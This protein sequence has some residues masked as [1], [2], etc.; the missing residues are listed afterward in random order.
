MC[1]KLFIEHK[2]RLVWSLMSICTR[3]YRSRGLCKT[4]CSQKLVHN[5]NI[6][7]GNSVEISDLGC[8]D[9]TYLDSYLLLACPFRRESQAIVITRTSSLLSCKPFNV[10][11]RCKSVKG[12]NTKLGILAHHDK[13]QLQDKEH[14]FESSSLEL[15]PFL[16]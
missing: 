5:R 12:I 8:G 11:N 9:K 4:K 2:D 1:H 13:M 10:A 6:I 7:N 15:C 3:G 14:N 16:T